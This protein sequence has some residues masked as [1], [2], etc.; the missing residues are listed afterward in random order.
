MATVKMFLETESQH[1]LSRFAKRSGSAT[2]IRDAL[3]TAARLVGS[4]HIPYVA[5][6]LDAYLHWNL[7]LDP[8]RR[9]QL[10][11]EGQVQ[12]S[13][14]TMARRQRI[15]LGKWL[16]QGANG[17]ALSSVR[18]VTDLGA[19]DGKMSYRVIRALLG[20]QAALSRVVLIDRQHDALKAAA[21]RVRTARSRAPVKLEYGDFRSIDLPVRNASSRLTFASGSLHELPATEKLQ[22]LVKV[23]YSSRFFILIELEADHDHASSGSASLI[24][25]SARFYD[26]LMADAFK[27]LSPQSLPTVVGVFLLDELLGIWLN[28]YSQRHNYH[29]GRNSW[30]DL[31]RQSNFKVLSVDEL[32]F[33]NL[34]TLYILAESLNAI[35]LPF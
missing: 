33:G 22:L 4:R 20:A 15:Q 34:R 27:S 3:S 12:W 9:L 28:T 19:G 2:R 23:A 31:I 25:R 21:E 14:T 10:D 32:D 13:H 30:L 26:A 17:T 16:Q 24:D 1:L 18:F 5:R 35:V 6:A 11:R 7:M 8:N 29:L